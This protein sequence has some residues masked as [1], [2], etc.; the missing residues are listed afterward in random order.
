MR[1]GKRVAVIG[2]GPAGLAAAQQLAR[3][4]HDVTVFEKNDRIGGLL[5][6]GIPNFKM[7]KHL[8]DRRMEQMR[9]EGVK[10]ET[11]AHVGGNVPVE[12]LRREFDAILLA[13]GAE[14]PRNLNVP[15][16]ELKGIHFAMEFLP[17]QNKP[18][19]R[20]YGRRDADSGHRQARG[21]HRRRRYRRRLPGHQPPPE[22][23][24]GASVRTAAQA[25]GRRAR[26][27]RRGRCGRCSCASKARTKK[28]AS[29]IGA[30]PPCSFTGDEHGNVKQL[31]AMRVGPPPKF[32]AMPGTEFTLDADLVLLAMGFLGPVQERHDRAA[33]REARRRAATWR[34]TTTTCRGSPASSRPATCA[35]ANRWWSGRSPK[36]ARPPKASIDS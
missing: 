30:S 9:A 24:I 26:P 2:I 18:L 23:A 22:G 34:R 7:E 11:N 6:Y 20:R 31:H 19:R 21:H 14:Q 3:A 4:G 33:G 13:G 5:R 17:Q 16:R 12:D 25:A 1:T 32:E 36:A 8:I 27:R 15:G 29:A 35:A 28:A 10:F